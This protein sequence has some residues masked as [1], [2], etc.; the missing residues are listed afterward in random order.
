MRD[1]LSYLPQLEKVLTHEFTHALVES[2][3]PRRTPTWLNEG[4]AVV[5]ENG[6]L[7]W[8]EQTIRSATAL[9]PLS[10]LHDSFLK[11]PPD[12]VPLAYAESAVAVRMLLERSG[13]M[14]LAMLLKDLNAGKEFAFA[15]DHYYTWS[16][17]EFQSVWYEPF[18]RAGS[19]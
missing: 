6:D 12:Q 13:P 17:L 2:L 19:P 9:V 5:F 8:A 10:Q 16:Y 11:L 1:A 14:A 15:F 3:S 4:L 7:T 18:K